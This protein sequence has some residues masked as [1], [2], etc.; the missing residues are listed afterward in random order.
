MS[1]R[2]KKLAVL[3]LLG[4]SLP[5][6]PLLAQDAQA[7]DAQEEEAEDEQ[8]TVEEEVFVVGSKSEVSRQ[9]LEASVGYFAEER[10]RN[11]VVTNIEDV[12]DRTANAFT[13]TASFGAYSIRGVNN[14]G[15]AG[16]FNGSNALATIFY[17][18]TALGITSADYIRPS[19]FDVS[20]VEILRGPQSSIQGPNSLIGAVLINATPAQF[21]SFNGRL[22]LEA[23]ELGTARVGVVQNLDLA[24]DVFALRLIAETRQ[25]DGAVTNTTTGRDDVQRT[26]DQ[27]YRVQGR[28]RPASRDDLFFDMTLMRVD[29]DSN[30]F[31][32]VQP[33][34]DGTIFS[35]TQPYDV[36]DEY[37][38]D[39]NLGNLLIDWQISDSW[40]LTSVTSVSDFGA[41]QRFDG[42]Q[43]AFDLLAVS[44]FIEESL[45]NQDFRLQYGGERLNVLL[46]AYY[47]DAEYDSGFSGVGIFPDGMGGLAPFNTTT[48]SVEE[49][50]QQAVFGR[51]N[52]SIT[53]SLTATIGVR[54]NREERTS[55][56]F[57]NN[58]GFISDLQASETFDQVIPN[59]ALSYAINDNTS[60]G[61]S[62]A[63]GFQAGGIAFAVFLGQSAP[64]DEEFTDNFEIFVRHRSRGGRLT[65]NANAFLI[66]WTDQQ[67]ATTLP[68][69][70]PGFDDIVLNAGE[71]S[72]QGAEVELEWRPVTP[73]SIFA[74]VGLIDSEFEEFVFNGVDFA[75]Q[76]FPQSPDYNVTVGATFQARSGWYGGS[77]LS[78]VD[79]AYTDISGPDIT[80]LSERTLLGARFG[81][82]GDR[83]RAY[84]W[85]RNLLDDDYEL[86]LFDG[87]N[88]GFNGAYG[89]A[90]EPRTLG[91]G[92]EVNW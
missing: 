38:S 91:A 86:G 87:R 35:R 61:A 49:I 11:D 40:E 69:G 41:D 81:Y 44:G 53:D 3:F 76:A 10:I 12:F 56:N 83:W 18:Q 14:N 25:T 77:T 22:L 59:A 15:V 89:R 85:G 23:G 30:P 72:I 55:I 74:S 1:G 8:P 19:M 51:A 80:A 45:L 50:E 46:G 88:F 4:A 75:G 84:V 64:Y 54:L 16:S 24:S 68:G 5:L 63:Q 32:L 21:N 39:L 79:E 27:T 13:G 7:Q 65:V 71:S 33:G 57:A 73:L 62:Y 90:G 67:T 34:P 42:D 36:D 29:S 31:G 78:L 26:D 6:P 37:P 43:T 52:W 17:N 2:F 58:N 47:S 9:E 20:S 70:F 92:F 28:F 60:I 48:E 82:G 66:D